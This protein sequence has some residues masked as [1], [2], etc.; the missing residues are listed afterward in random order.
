MADGTCYLINPTVTETETNAA[1]GFERGLY[2]WDGATGAFTV[3]TLNDTN[4]NAGLSDNDGMLNATVFVFRAIPSA[5]SRTGLLSEAGSKRRATRRR[6]PSLAP[7]SP[8]IRH[9]MP[10]LS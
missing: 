5:S 4:G 10:V 1:P 3:T 9:A 2:T 7:G 8:A 6:T